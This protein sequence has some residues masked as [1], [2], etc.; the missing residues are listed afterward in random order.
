MK[1]PKKAEVIEEV[2]DVHFINQLCTACEDCVAVCPTGSIFYGMGKFVID[3]DS[4]HGCGICAR[5]CPVDA[6]APLST[7]VTQGSGD[8]AHGYESE[9][10]D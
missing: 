6:I 3:T 7:V 5:V 1:T 9:E 2:R 10:E 4:C 8:P